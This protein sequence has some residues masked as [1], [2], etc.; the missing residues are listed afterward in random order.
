MPVLD[1]ER[2]STTRSALRYRPIDT[3]QQ[4]GPAPVATRQRRSRPETRAIAAP[5]VLDE[6]EQEEASQSAR[7]KRTTSSVPQRKTTQPVQYTRRM[8][9][10]FFIGVGLLATTLLW[11]GMTQAVAWGTEQYNTLVYG[12]PRTF[13]V[14]AV[15]GHGDSAQRPSHFIALNLHGFVTI[16]EFPGGDLSR[17]R[18][19]FA[20]SAPGPDAD[21]AVVTLRF[22][23]FNHNG[24]PDMLVDIGGIQ[25]VLVNTGSTFRAP[26]PAEQQQILQQLQQY[27]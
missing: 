17:A 5:D 8:H 6:R 10:L 4:T 2:R 14:D 22:I 16:M 27:Q 20:A 23:D 13:Q 9:P 21:H 25:S 1:T 18:E 3:D 7:P 15:V 26:T 12:Y 19:L 11:I 24:K